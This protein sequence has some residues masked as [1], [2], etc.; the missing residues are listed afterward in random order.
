MPDPQTDLSPGRLCERACRWLQSGSDPNAFP[1]DPEPSVL[2]SILAAAQKTRGGANRA[3]LLALHLAMAGRLA[4]AWEP[5]SAGLR[6]AN[7]ALAR[8]RSVPNLLAHAASGADPFDGHNAGSCLFMECLCADPD[9]PFADGALELLKACDPGNLA[10][11]VSRHDGALGHVLNY[12][13]RRK[14]LDAGQLHAFLKALDEK[15][16][17][18][19]Y[20]DMRSAADAS[21]EFFELFDLRADPG[22]YRQRPDGQNLAWSIRPGDGHLDKIRRLESRGVDISASLPGVQDFARHCESL[23][24]GASADYARA[25]IQAARDAQCLLG[26]SRFTRE[27]LDHLLALGYQIQAPDG[28]PVRAGNPAPKTPGGRSL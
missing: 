28:S 6:C 10:G 25:K 11:F 17:K 15:G 3:A 19:S 9:N 4:S 13:H 21:D 16:W 22:V 24:M 20:E 23:G 14:S 18:P 8:L 7:K 27:A 2:S 12:L 1:F 5:R 26:A